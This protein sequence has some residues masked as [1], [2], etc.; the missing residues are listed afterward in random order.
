V[1]QEVDHA[2][3]SIHVPRLSEDVR[4]RPINVGIAGGQDNVLSLRE[5]QSRADLEL[6]ARDH[7]EKELRLRQGRVDDH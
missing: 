2:G 1:A 6:R 5:Q 3:L 7:V 4:D